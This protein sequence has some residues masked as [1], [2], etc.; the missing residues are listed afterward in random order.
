MKKL[1]ALLLLVMLLM[2]L[3]ICGGCAETAQRDGLEVMLTTDKEV[4]DALETVYA[5]LTVKNTNSFDVGNV[6]MKVEAPEGYLLSDGE[7]TRIGTLS[8]GETQKLLVTV[9]EAT[10]DTPLLPQTGD[11]SHG[12]IWTLLLVAAVSV[13]C[14]LMIRSPQAKRVISLFLCMTIIAPYAM[15]VAPVLAQESDE[16][17]EIVVENGVTI[18]EKGIVLTGVVSYELGVGKAVTPEP[19][20]IVAQPQDYTASVGD[21]VEI[22]V[23]ATGIGLE[24]Q[25]Y[26]RNA[27][28]ITWKTSSQTTNTYSVTMKESFDGREVYCKVTDATGASVKSNTAKMLLPMVQIIT[29]PVDAWAY[30]GEKVTTSVEA[31]GDGL[32]YKWYYS[33]NGGKSYKESSSETQV[34]STTMRSDR[35]GRK[36]Y[37]K[38]TDAYGHTVKSDIATL[39]FV[40]ELR[41]TTQPTDV[42]ACNGD[43]VTVSLKAS[44]DGLEYAWYYK[45]ADMDSFVK[46]SSTKTTCSV[47]MNDERNGRLMYCVVS[48][49]YGNQVQSDTIT[50]TMAEPVKIV[51]QPENQTVSAGEQASFTVAA[52]GDGLTY[53]WYYRDTGSSVWKTS[54]CK[55][56]TYS[57]TMKESRD[58]R[59]VRCKVT[60]AYGKTATS[61]TAKAFLPEVQI[62]THPEDQTVYEGNEAKFTVEATGDGLTYQWYYRKSSSSSWKKSSQ[63]TDT[64]TITASESN[65]GRQVRCKVTDAYDNTVTSDTAELTVLDAIEFTYIVSNGEVEISAYL[66][67]AESVTVPSTLEGY[68]VTAIGDD[69]F[70]GNETLKHVTL[71]DSIKVIGKRAFKGCTALTSM[72]TYAM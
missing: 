1:C 16:D 12:M 42:K 6:T 22:S 48:D 45:N 56:E 31:I 32:E 19:L 66:G 51:T 67:N 18:E 40:Y 26:Y 43:K 50:L 58:G 29:Q 71:P 27:G 5:E 17:K 39:H 20:V 4:Y 65:D 63:T 60:D 47:T 61:E 7:E 62:V 15:Q 11:G 28:T 30:D 8:A 33:T 2:N 59:R 24:Y 49:E 53:Q 35:D 72:D 70:A 46:S 14:T 44:G 13:M 25:W 10:A 54:S 52:E 21:R 9:R 68:P 23:E 64:Y 37:C 36:V 57:F 3:P 55:T 69:A 34:Y 38:I 41:I